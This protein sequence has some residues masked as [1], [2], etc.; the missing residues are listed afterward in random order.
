MKRSRHYGRTVSS[1]QAVRQTGGFVTPYVSRTVRPRVVPGYTRSS[2]FYGRFAKPNG[3]MKF[4]D[5]DLD[6]AV[7]AAG[8]NATASINL[9]AQGV[10][11]STRVGRKC[12]ITAINWRYRVFRRS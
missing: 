1:R 2:G 3:E 7:I 12:T 11:E 9:I 5:V 10:T 6:D 8:A 4:H